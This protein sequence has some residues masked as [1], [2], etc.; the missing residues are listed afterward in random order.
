M[1]WH[2][3]NEIPQWLQGTLALL[4]LLLG[5]GL[6]QW[7]L[8]VVVTRWLTRLGRKVEGP[9]A[10]L[11]HR[12][13]LRRGSQIVLPLAVHL[14]VRAVPYL[15]D[16]LL[17][18]I[19]NVALAMTVLTAARTLLR[20]L[21]AVLDAHT[22]QA[23]EH[24]H[25]RSR[26]VKMYVQLGQLFVGL[27]ALVIMIAALSD[28]SPLIVLSGFGAMSAVVLLVFQDTLRSFAAGMQIESN[29]ML[30][31]GDWIEIP[32][33]GADGH[34]IDVALN[35]VK[36]QNWDKTIVTVPTWRLMSESFKNW[37]GMSESGG[38]RIMRTLQIDA[39]SIRFLSDEEIDRLGQIRLLA[40]YIQ[41]KRSAIRISRAMA[42]SELGPEMGSVP[43]NQRRLTNIG[44]FR[45]YVQNYLEAHHFIR[46][47]MWRLVR[48]MQ[49]TESGVPLQLYCFTNTT[50]LVE[51]EAIQSDIFDHLLAVLPEFGLY[52]F[53][54]PSSSGLRDAL[55]DW[56]AITAEQARQAVAAAQAEGVARTATA[57]AGH[58]P[59]A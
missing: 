54:N 25:G 47:D 42:A 37:R 49:P 13:V 31:V 29:D 26:S 32:Q 50:A 3:L 34:V 28:K 21:E 10:V 52:V 4:V 30:R 17:R 53:Q 35:T 11:L 51:Y 33:A 36:V 23:A 39:G 59:A 55:A 16:T 40:D 18:V 22:Q 9:M 1:E 14:G 19:E 38:R 5:A 57:S 12:D 20:I 58:E 27:A 15:P 45:A 46:Q 41:E 2:K 56:R 43:T 44:T 48:M 8:R 6:L 24:G 7:L